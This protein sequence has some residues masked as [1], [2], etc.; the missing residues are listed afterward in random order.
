MF[1]YQN[2]TAEQL[3]DSAILEEIEANLNFLEEFE[4]WSDEDRNDYLAGS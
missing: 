3:L 1:F 4:S 2:W